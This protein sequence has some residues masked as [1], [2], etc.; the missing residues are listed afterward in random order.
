ME[1]GAERESIIQVMGMPPAEFDLITD[2]LMRLGLCSGAGTRLMFIDHS[3]QVFQLKDKNVISITQLGY[4]FVNA[5]RSPPKKI[6][7]MRLE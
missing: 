3:D 7:E 1:R 4:E 2:N 6:G 5:C